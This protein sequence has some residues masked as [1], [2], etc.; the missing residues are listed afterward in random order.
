VLDSDD[1]VPDQEVLE[2]GCG[3][4]WLARLTGGSLP[5]VRVFTSIPVCSLFRAYF[6]ER[7]SARQEL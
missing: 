4:A 3:A 6:V 1:K 2:A 7:R 5:I